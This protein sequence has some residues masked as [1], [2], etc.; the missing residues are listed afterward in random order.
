MGLWVPL[1]PQGRSA[2]SRLF[3]N[4]ALPSPNADGSRSL[5]G[6]RAGGTCPSPT[7]ELQRENPALSPS[8]FCAAEQP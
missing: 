7:F 5:L 8:H 2:A 3:A 4:P 6:L 1:L